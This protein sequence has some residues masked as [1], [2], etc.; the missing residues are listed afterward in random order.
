[1]VGGEAPI[2]Q[3]KHV[4]FSGIPIAREA[5]AEEDVINPAVNVLLGV[6]MG[7]GDVAGGEAA[8]GGGF[9]VAIALGGAG[10]H[11][12]GCTPA[13]QNGFDG[14]GVV[15]VVEIAEDDEADVGIGGE[16]GV[17]FLAEDFGFFEAHVRFIGGGD[18]A[19]GFQVGGDESEGI[20]GV[21]RDVHLGETAADEERVA[22]HEVG[23]IGV[24]MARGD[25]KTA[26]DGDVDVGIVT[27][28]VFPIRQRETGGLE[29]GLQFEQGIGGAD[30][31]EGEDVGFEGENAFA[32]FGLG[33]FG[34]R[35]TGA[36]GLIEV[37][38]DVV[39][40]DAKGVSGLE[41]KCEK[42]GNKTDDDANPGKNHAA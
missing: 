38:F 10:V 41:L 40:G 37:I 7:P 22:V 34:F 8:V 12:A 32:D 5:V 20:V 42:E 6:K 17:N 29:G 26:E 28:D 24:R 27:G 18:G 11:E 9:A 33:G 36:A 25:G 2:W 30:F 16:A 23:V 1:M 14:R 35:G 13:A 3:R 31:F 21:H 39:G 19:F 4:S 15:G